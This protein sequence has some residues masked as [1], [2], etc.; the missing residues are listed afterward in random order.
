VVD[1]NAA[2]HPRGDAVELRA[3]LPVDAALVD[4]SQIHLVHE[5][6]RLQRV[7]ATLAAQVRCRAPVQ[8]V[9]DEGHQPIAR[10][11]VA[12]SPGPQQRRDIRCRPLQG[13][14]PE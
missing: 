2:H 12:G 11:L 4:E 14:D 10:L 3:I 8:C 6:R 9:V 1:E 7:I 13:D 5:R